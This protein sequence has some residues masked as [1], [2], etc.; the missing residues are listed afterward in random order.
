[1]VFFIMFGYLVLNWIW[2]SIVKRDKLNGKE[3]NDFG[4]HQDERNRVERIFIFFSS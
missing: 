1:M 4:D 3:Q 2:D